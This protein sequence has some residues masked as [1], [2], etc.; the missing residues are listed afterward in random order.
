MPGGRRRG[1]KLPGRG[2]PGGAHPEFPQ[3][4]EAPVAHAGAVVVDG[5]VA[6]F[7]LA[8][9]AAH[10]PVLRGQEQDPRRWVPPGL[11]QQVAVERSG[12]PGGRAVQD[13]PGQHLRKLGGG[14]AGRERN[15]QCRG[16]HRLSPACQRGLGTASTAS[17]NREE[18]G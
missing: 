2:D 10:Q 18:S 16:G 17:R 5:P 12:Q 6:S 9:L 15:G 1:G 14:A 3:P 7:R 4:G 13:G 11:G 8:Y